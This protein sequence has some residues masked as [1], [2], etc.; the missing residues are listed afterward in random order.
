MT[1]PLP[2]HKRIEPV[3]RGHRR[4]VIIL[5]E[6]EWLLVVPISIRSLHSQHISSTLDSE[7]NRSKRALTSIHLRTQSSK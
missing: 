2:L 7:S 1:V 6:L 3:A 4:E 5:V